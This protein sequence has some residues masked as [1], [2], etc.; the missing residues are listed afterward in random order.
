MR[1][2]DF[3]TPLQGSL[4]ARDGD[5]L[6]D[7]GTTS[8]GT[9]NNFVVQDQEQTNW[10]W[11]AISASI[12]EFFGS[13]FWTQCKIASEELGVDCSRASNKNTCNRQW[14]LDAPLRL[15]GHLDQM[16]ERSCNLAEVIEEINAGRP[17]CCR[18]AY[19]RSGGGHFVAIGGWSNTSDG[20]S[21]LQVHDPY[22]G[23]V[24][25]LYDKFASGYRAPGDHWSHSYFTRA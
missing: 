17:L 24:I 22:L 6:E 16:V 2:A 11:A 12:A 15:V 1:L 19:R 14:S 20:K 9:L 21:Y 4:G 10:C 18:I 5:E 23:F 13:S 25:Q 3:L 7:S 8:S